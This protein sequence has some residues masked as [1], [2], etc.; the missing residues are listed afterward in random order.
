[1]KSRSNGDLD[2]GFGYS[3]PWK[4]HTKVYTVYTKGTPKQAKEKWECLKQAQ[5]V[6]KTYHCHW[7]IVFV[8][9]NPFGKKYTW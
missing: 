7:M 5:P 1:M 6:N 8:H 2:D 4:G 3:A 9:H